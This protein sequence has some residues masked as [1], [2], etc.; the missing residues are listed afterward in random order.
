[1]LR[2]ICAVPNPYDGRTLATVLPEIEA[3]IGAPLARV[4]AAAA[5]AAT[6]NLDF[7]APRARIGERKS[8]HKI[9]TINARQC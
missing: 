2:R 1:L 8:P 3:Q 6:T 4:A 9:T 5:I 7:S